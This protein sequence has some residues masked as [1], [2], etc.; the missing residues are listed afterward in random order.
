MFWYYVGPFTDRRWNVL[1]DGQRRP[2][3]YDNEHDAIVAAVEAARENFRK[4]GVSSGVRIK[5][6]DDW[7]VALT[8]GVNHGRT[9]GQSPSHTGRG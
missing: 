4:K 6:E 9:A 5:Q 3:M 1:F 8:F 2:Y 7:A